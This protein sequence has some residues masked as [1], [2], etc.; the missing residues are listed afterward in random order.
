MVLFFQTFL[1]AVLSFQT[2]DQHVSFQDTFS[3]LAE[4]A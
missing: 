1:R 3:I 4:V 2:D